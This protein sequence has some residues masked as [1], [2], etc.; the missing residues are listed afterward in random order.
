MNVP[1]PAH[2]K[3][4]KNAPSTDFNFPKEQR[5]SWGCL[6][7]EDNE[8][9]AEIRER[10]RLSRNRFF[11]MCTC[12]VWMNQVGDRR[13]TCW[14]Q[15]WWSKWIDCRRLPTGKDS[16]IGNEVDREWEHI[17]SC[18]AASTQNG[19]FNGKTSVDILISKVWSLLDDMLERRNKTKL[20]KK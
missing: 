9:P 20:Q 2:L 1:A 6:D 19:I 14:H 4:S 12:L 18:I 7:R 17:S 10:T 5:A 15:I 16:T 11:Q 13:Q 8:K 3:Q